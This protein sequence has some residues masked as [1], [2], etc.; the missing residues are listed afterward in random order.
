MFKF[1]QIQV[2]NKKVNEVFPF[3]ENPEN[4]EIITPNELRFNI[5]SPKPL[6]MKEGAEFRYTIKLGLLKFP[7]RTLITKYD[8]NKIFIDEQKFGPYKKWKH[9]HLFED[10]DGK[11]KMTDIIEYDLFLYPLKNLINN[12]Y[13]SKNI[14]KIFDFRKNYL[15]EKFN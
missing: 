3:F 12:L 8:P 5:I 13:V 7:W 9:T 6:V 14:K 1:E 11:T 4:L 15:R 2:F 10:I